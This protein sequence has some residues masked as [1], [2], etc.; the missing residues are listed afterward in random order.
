V[1][2]LIYIR[3]TLTSLTEVAIPFISQEVLLGLGEV[4]MHRVGLSRGAK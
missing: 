3:N 1:D 4:N 2:D